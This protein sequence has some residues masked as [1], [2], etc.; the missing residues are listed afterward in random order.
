MPNRATPFVPIMLAA[1]V[2]ASTPGSAEPAADECI[3]RP[4]AAPPAGSHWY[5]RIDRTSK[6]RCWFLGPEGAKVRREAAPRRAPA[7]VAARPASPPLVPPAP[8]VEAESAP[9]AQAGFASRWSDYPAYAS[10]SAGAPRHEPAVDNDTG[11]SVRSQQPLEE[12]RHPEPQEQGEQEKMPLVWPV[13]SAAELD[14]AAPAPESALRLEYMLALLAAALAVAAILGQRML[15]RSARSAPTQ[16]RGRS[17]AP[18]APP[19]VARMTPAAPVRR[20]R[21]AGRGASAPAALD[22]SRDEVERRLLRLLHDWQRIA[23]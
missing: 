18:P 17:E 12:R 19:A 2:A 21:P 16:R 23:A 5:Y 4:N 6:R 3:G 10:A 13:L 20:A 8:P 14:A 7:A 11:S 15:N 1:L 9:A 22:G